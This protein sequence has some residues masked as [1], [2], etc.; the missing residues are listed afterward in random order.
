MG[1]TPHLLDKN[2]FLDTS[3]FRVLLVSPKK[4]KDYYNK[5]LINEIYVCDYVR[6]EFLRGYIKTCIDFFFLLSMPQYESFSEAFH[7][8]THKFQ[9]REHKNLEAMVANL[10]SSNKCSDDKEKMLNY[11]AE[12]IRRLISKSFLKYKK[13]GNDNTYCIKGRKKL[14]FDPKNPKK[15]FTDY[16]ELLKDNNLSKSCSIEKFLKEKEANNIDKLFENKELNLVSKKDGFDKLIN[17][18][19]K[20]KEKKKISCA[21]CS[22]MGDSIIALIN[23]NN[24]EWRLEHTDN[25]FDYLCNILKIDH[26]SHPYDVEIMQM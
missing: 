2:H 17:E 9:I 15:Y 4:V 5:E 19:S 21:Y 24:I 8:W 1:W 25:S 14:V 20:L 10:I 26:K 6:M 3:V 13:V 18:L 23:K 12:Y 16:L 11:L 7:V 22:R